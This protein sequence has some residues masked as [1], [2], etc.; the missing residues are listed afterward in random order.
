MHPEEIDD[1]GLGVDQGEI[2][3]A[4][5]IDV[6]RSA[7]F[8]QSRQVLPGAS[9]RDPEM[10]ADWSQDL[11]AGQEVVAY[12][13]HGHE[14]SRN[15]ARYLGAQGRKAR[16]LRGGFESWKNAGLPLAHKPG[17]EP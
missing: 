15:A 1:E 13:V 12:C 7:A 17:V 11:D 2:A 9:W 3:G 5:L 16:F 14:V 10:I 4:L 8:A 6:R